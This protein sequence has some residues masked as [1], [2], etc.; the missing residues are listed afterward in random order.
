[1]RG[2]VC[3][4]RSLLTCSMGSGFFI[5]SHHSHIEYILGYPFLSDFLFW[6]AFP[7]CFN[8]FYLSS[9]FHDDVPCMWVYICP[10]CGEFSSFSPTENTLHGWK[11]FLNYLL[12]SPFFFL[13]NFSPFWKDYY[14]DVGPFMLL[15]FN[16]FNSLLCLFPFALWKIFLIS[17]SKPSIGFSVYVMILYRSAQPILVYG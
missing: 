15:V 11:L 9:A 16:L 10:L 3:L 7:G 2:E 12:F 1:M 6:F 13:F 14:S 5:F 4:S 17:S 8:F